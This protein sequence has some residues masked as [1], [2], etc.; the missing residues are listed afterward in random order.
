MDEMNVE[1]NVDSTTENV[2]AKN[3]E[4][5]TA[6]SAGFCF[7]VKRAIDRAYEVIEKSQTNIYTYGPIIHN[8]TVTSDLEKKGVRI[9]HDEKELESLKDATIV[10]RSHGIGKKVYDICEANHL[11][12]IDATCP[13]V[14]KIHD[15]VQ[16]HSLEGVTVIIVGD[17]KHPEVE[18]IKGWSDGYVIQDID[19]F[20]NLNLDKS[21]LFCVV[22][23]TTFNHT[24]FKK[25]VDKMQDMGYDILC[26]NTICNA[27]KERQKEALDIAS[28]VDAM[29]VIG[30]K[31]SSNTNKLYEI[32]SN[33][34]ARTFMIQTVADLDIEW[35]QGAS[36]IGITAGAS[37]PDIIVREVQNYV[38]TKF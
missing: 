6:K 5:I 21:R 22:A 13:F 3:I 2:E 18:G 12:I 32:C 36:K 37:T 1:K 33:V 15:I 16:K 9:I 26:F 14:S 34:C 11:E 28:R 27:T 20:I 30:G 23:Q 19:D 38:R 31:N 8:E 25:I 29:I 7:G 17:P 4:I 35:F 24:K 10:I